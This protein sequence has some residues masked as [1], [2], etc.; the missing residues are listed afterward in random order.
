MGEIKSTLDIIMEKTKGLTMSA[1]EKAAFQK[2][3]TEDKAKGILQK[4]ID[5][6]FNQDCLKSE[7]LG[8][9]KTRQTMAFVRRLC[10][11]RIEPGVD[12][13]RLLDLLQDLAGLDT[14]PIYKVLSKYD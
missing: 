8:L 12:S 1:E 6:V 4:Y 11:E 10:L 5:G 14:V 9:D 7:L 2:K 3:E 13:S